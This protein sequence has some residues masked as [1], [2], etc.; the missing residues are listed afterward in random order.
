VQL[1]VSLPYLIAQCTL[2]DYFKKYDYARREATRK[3]IG[4]AQ[5]MLHLGARCGDKLSLATAA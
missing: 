2:T 5:L 3:N 4:K 1:L